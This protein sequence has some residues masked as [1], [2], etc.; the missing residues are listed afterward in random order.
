MDEQFVQHYDKFKTN[1][2]NLKL[3]SHNS[4]LLYVLLIITRYKVIFNEKTLVE[5]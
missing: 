2:T 1:T 3:T 5:Y 4:L